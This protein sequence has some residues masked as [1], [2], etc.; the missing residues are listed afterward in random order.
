M[1]SKTEMALETLRNN[2]NCAQSVFSAF[3]EDY[4]LPCELA[5]KISSGLGGG[6]RC[7]EV[8][9]AATGAVLVIGLSCGHHV[10]GDSESK[11]FNN[12]ETA[13]FMRRFHEKSGSYTCRDI[14]GIDTS[15][16]DNR[17][18]AKEMG[19][20]STVCVDMVKNA[21]EILEDMGY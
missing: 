13:E 15:I 6:V 5:L 8:C 21:V 14:L 10:L 16:G 2:F 18:K 1:S 11:E 7:G 17:L 4:S 19:L 3:S 12:K 20:F 9:G